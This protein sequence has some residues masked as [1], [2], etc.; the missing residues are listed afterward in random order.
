MRLPNTCHQFVGGNF[1]ALRTY[2]LIKNS[3]VSTPLA[4]AVLG[5]ERGFPTER[6]AIAIEE[7]RAR[8]CRARDQAARHGVGRERRVP[9]SHNQGTRQAG[10]DGY[11]FSAGVRRRRDGLRRI[12]DIHSGTLARRWVRWHH[13]RGAHVA[14]HESY[15]SRRE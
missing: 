10:A 2:V 4:V 5:G 6:R 14:L 9:A 8:V 13:R 1:F 12:R 11:G 15:F 3:T 7:E